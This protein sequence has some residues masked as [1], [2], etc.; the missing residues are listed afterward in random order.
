MTPRWPPLPRRLPRTAPP[1]RWETYD[2]YL[3]RLAAANRVS[4]DDL[5]EIAHHYHDDPAVL[6]QLAALTGYPADAL[7][8]AIPELFH[9]Q[10]LGATGLRGRCPA[11]REFINDIRPPCQHCAA[12]A[13]ADP[14]IARIWATHDANICL[15]HHRW[16]GDGNDEPGH[17]LDLRPHP[18]IVHAQIRHQRIVRRYGRPATR[19]A[20]HCARGLWIHMSTTPGYTQQRQARTARLRD[21]TG[22][23][24]TEET[25][26]NAAAYPETV[27]FTA[28]LASPYWRAIIL[29]RKPASNQRF[30][31]EFRRRLAP[32]HHENGYPRLLFWIRRDLERD[33]TATDDTGPYPPPTD[34]LH[35]LLPARPIRRDTS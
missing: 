8:H 19:S 17:Q 34:P 35:S 9:H 14:H 26:A 23:A 30:H 6:G 22:A 25:A 10:A 27:A 18:D 20:F 2:S 4:F 28:L 7:R 29:A 3:G 31:R 12:A 24:T 16:T 21:Q 15:R 1:L 5:D 13:G 33:R 32:G 11:P